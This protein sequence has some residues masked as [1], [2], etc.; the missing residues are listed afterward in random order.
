ML[1]V[2][3][4]FKTFALPLEPAQQRGDTRDEP[5]PLHSVLGHAHVW[6]KQADKTHPNWMG[7]AVDA[8][9]PDVESKQCL[10]LL[11]RQSSAFPLA[12]TEKHVPRA[13]NLLDRK[14]FYK[15][16]NIPEAFKL[17][18]FDKCALVGSSGVLRKSKYTHPPSATQI[19]T[20]FL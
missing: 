4:A 19:T 9:I 17:P 1:V 10:R 5:H 20:S 16:P 7:P 2:V 6:A 15:G 11:A 13:Y 14:Y 8:L 3:A 18:C 12:I